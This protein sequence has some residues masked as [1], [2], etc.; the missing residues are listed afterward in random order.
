MFI[1]YAWLIPV[2]PLIFSPIALLFG[3]KMPK[4]GAELGIPGAGLSL[5]LASL[6]TIEYLSYLQ[7]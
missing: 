1:E 6:I 7:P 5:T 3:E 4:K 2:I